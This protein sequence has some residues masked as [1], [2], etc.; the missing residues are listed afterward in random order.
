MFL[1]AS[2]GTKPNLLWCSNMKFFYT[3]PK[4][5]VENIRSPA[6][7]EDFEWALFGIMNTS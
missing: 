4:A 6:P 3:Y 1:A 2:I 5:N 7:F